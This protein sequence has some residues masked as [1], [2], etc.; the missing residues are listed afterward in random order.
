MNEAA[1]R[2][3]RGAK[4]AMI[5]QEPMTALDPVFTIGE[6]IAETIVRHEGMSYARRQPARARAAGD[7]ADPVGGAAAEDLSARD[8]RRHAAAGDDRAGAV[9]PALG[10]AGRRAD[11]GARR[12]RA[13]PDHAAAAPAAAGAR[14][15]GGVRHARCR[16]RGRGRRPDRRDVCRPLGR[17][18]PDRGGDRRA[19]A[20]LHGR[21]CWPRRC[22]ARRSGA[23]GGDPRHAA[24]PARA[25]RGLQLRAA[26]P[27]LPRT[28]A[29]LPCRRNSR[30]RPST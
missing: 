6:Q 23:A 10:A 1:L 24:G 27:L 2:E 28:A 14:H 13:D 7:G 11:H 15:G 30:S 18:R 17:G 19:G 5:F 20:S 3:V 16:R 26:L 12:D 29:A 9:L 25:A 22:W 8:V 21:A 4:V